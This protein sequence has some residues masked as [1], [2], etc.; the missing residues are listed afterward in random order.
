M[1]QP[2]I[3][4]AVEIAADDDRPVERLCRVDHC[5]ELLEAIGEIDASV[6]VH[7][8]DLDRSGRRL[9]DRTERDAV[10]APEAEIESS[11][12]ENQR[13]VQRVSGEQRQSRAPA[14]AGRKG[15]P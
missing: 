15:V 3:V 14:P 11:Q 12:R 5:S 6:E 8:E 4:V 7:V 9:D 10:T 2:A 1:K 13:A